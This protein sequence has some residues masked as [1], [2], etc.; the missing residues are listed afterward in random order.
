MI[1]EFFSYDP[2]K[3]GYCKCVHDVN[4]FIE[5]YIN[6]VYLNVYY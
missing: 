1:F 5:Y 2:I 4:V 3:L 6:F